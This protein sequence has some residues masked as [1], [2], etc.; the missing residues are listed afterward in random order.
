MVTEPGW[1]QLL[2]TWQDLDVP[3]GWHAEIVGEFITLVPPP[4]FAHNKIAD[5]IHRALVRATPDDWGIYQTQGVS[6]PGLAKLY[7]PDLVVVQDPDSIEAIDNSAIP[8]DCVLLV[9]EVTSKSNA[10]SDRTDKVA[11]YA[12][13]PV[14]F[15]LLIDRF[16]E[17]GPAVT[18]YSEPEG[19]HYQH[20][21][22]GKFG[23]PVELPEPLGLTLE[24]ADF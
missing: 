12:A 18:L 5:R 24:T 22:R 16:D 23:E 17:A 2:G 14:P 3:E 8:A 7:I 4:G 6:I 13:G 11:G 9:A 19:G 21:V 15:Y 20:S 10:D 1:A